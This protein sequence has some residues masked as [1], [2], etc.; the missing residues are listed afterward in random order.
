MHTI[1]SNEKYKINSIF[2]TVHKY[3]KLPNNK[4]AF[5][6]LHKKYHKILENS[7]GKAITKECA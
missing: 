1:I 5:T 6:V 2:M 4:P 3:V 7:N